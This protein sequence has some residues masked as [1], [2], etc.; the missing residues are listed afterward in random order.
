MQVDS[1]PSPFPD[2]L[3]P[4]SSP[5][6]RRLSPII[7]VSALLALPATARTNDPEAAAMAAALPLIAQQNWDAADAAAQPAGPLAVD[8]VEWNRLRA[9]D[10]ALS[11]YTAFLAR[12]P[13]WPGMDLLH[14]RGEDA[15]EATTPPDQVIA[16]FAANPP[17]TATGSMALQTALVA[18]GLSKQAEAEARRAWLALSYG[19]TDQAAQLATFPQVL[20]PLIDQRLDLVLWRGRLTEAAQMI[21]LASPGAQALARAR[22]ALQA[23]ASGV[24][25]LVAAV[26]AALQSNPGLAHDRFAFRFDKGY[27]DSAADLLLERSTS[28]KSLGDPAEWA[29]ERARLARREMVSGDPKRAYRIAAHD[30]LTSG[31]A[32][33]DLEF[34]AGYISLHYL[35]DA[36]TALAHF[37]NLRAGVTTPISLSRAA[38]W[39]GRAE[40]ALGDTKAAKAAFAYGATFQTAFYGLLSAERIGQKLDPS[41]LSDQRAPDWHRAPFLSSSTL[42]AGL[43]LLK[44]GDRRTGKR[45]LLQLADGLDATGLGQL[46]DMALAIGQPHVGVL[47]AKKAADRG[48]ILPRAYFPLTDLARQ[49]LPVP[50]DLALAIARR[51]SEFDETVISPAG[52]LGLMQVMPATAARMSSKAGLDYN[53][54][55]MTSD[56]DYNAKLGSAYLAQLID[57]FGPALTLVAAGYNAGPNRATQWLAQLGDPRASGIDPVDWIETVPFTETRDYI[58]RVSESYEIYRSKLAGKSLPIRLTAELKGQ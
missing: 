36:K 31:G 27:Y 23:G 28:A 20:S 49:K 52:A 9:G 24:D 50:T 16:Y 26:P 34:L 25:T 5:V 8:I 17:D 39:E 53:Q 33:A 15:L 10:G 30:Y 45:F 12:H 43:L 14:R 38:Y 54:T 29:S 1:G 44:A 3:T 55:R 41:L 6:F 13:D 21:P 58:M 37:R 4:E 47:I 42:Q 18:R 56:A 32:Y 19:A 51:E 7:L 11:D 22:I 57:Q 35:R 48:I 46:A 2:L 40:E